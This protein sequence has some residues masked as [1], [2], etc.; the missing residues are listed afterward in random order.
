MPENARRPPPLRL[1]FA[2]TLS[3]P[4]RLDAIGQFVALAAGA[5]VLLAAVRSRRLVR[6][7]P[8]PRAIDKFTRL[9]LWNGLL[10]SI[11]FGTVILLLW[12]CVASAYGLAILRG[13]SHGAETVDDWPNVLLLEGLGEWA[14]VAGGLVLSALPGVLA[15][16]LWNWLGVS[17]ALGVASE[18]AGVVSRRSVVGVG[19]QFAGR[20]AFAVGMEERAVRM[21]GLGGVLSGDA[22]HRRPRR[23]AADRPSS[24]A[25]V[26]RPASLRR[27]FSLAAVG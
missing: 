26:G 12:T 19:N 1:F 11:V 17:R 21:A 7:A 22:G 16:P 15:T 14:Y 5:V 10:L 9:M 24:A 4:F 27:A 8:T 3:F 20:S 2:D 25:A 23:R 6:N 18:P 13:T